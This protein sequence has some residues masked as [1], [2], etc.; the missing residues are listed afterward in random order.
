MKVQG[1]SRRG[2][3]HLPK[4]I[5]LCSSR[6]QRRGAARGGAWRGTSRWRGGAVCAWVC[7][8]SGQRSRGPVHG[9]RLQRGWHTVSVIAYRMS[10]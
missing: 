9:T 3:D 7:G 4:G 5:R 8:G 6:S 1:R 2:Y 10:Q